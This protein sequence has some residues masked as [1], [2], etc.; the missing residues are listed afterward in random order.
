MEGVIYSIYHI[1]HALERLGNQHDVIYASDGFARSS[2]W[3]QMLADTFGKPVK[4]P[5]SHQSSA[6]GAAWLVL[7]S[8]ENYHLKDIKHSVTMSHEIEPNSVNHDKYQH[9][10]S[11]YKNLYDQLKTT[12]HQLP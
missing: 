1:G 4:I 3:L 9:I 12:F 10:F 6:W 7:C 11:I 5:N 2:L 8:V